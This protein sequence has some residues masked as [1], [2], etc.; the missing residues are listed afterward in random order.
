MSSKA[1]LSLASNSPRRRQLLALGGWMFHIVPANVDE[2]PFPGEDSRDYVIRMA[3]SKVRAV[4]GQLHPDGVAIAADTS[5]IARQKILGKPADAKEAVKVLRHLRGR[6]HRVHTAIAVLLYGWEDPVIDTCTTNV[7]MRNYSDEEIF[8]YV[9]SADPFDKAGGYGIQ[10]HRFHPVARLNGCYA[11]VMGLPLCHL[12]R[13]LDRL[14]I[15]PRTDVPRSCQKALKY[16]CPVF[17][18]VLRG[19]V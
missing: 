16:K 11:N 3:E 18:R 7:P 1:V 4:A 10:N 17:G 14:G 13:V 19:V 8:T 15:P 2:S 6:V 12:T 5:V 9:A